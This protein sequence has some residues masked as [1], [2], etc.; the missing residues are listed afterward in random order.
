MEQWSDTPDHWQKGSPVTRTITIAAQG[1][2]A[3]QIPDLNIAKMPGVNIYTD[4]AKRRNIKKD[5][6]VT[7]MLEQK[8]TYIPTTADFIIIPELKLN[9]WDLKT[10]TNALATLNTLAVQIKTG[11][12]NTADSST[13]TLANKALKANISSIPTASKNQVAPFYL[14]IWFWLAAL[15]FVMWVIT[16]SLFR[17]KRTNDGSIINHKPIESNMDVEL[18]TTDIDFKL[19]CVQGN[20]FQAQ[21]YILGWAKQKWP[22]MPINLAKLRGLVDDSNF[23]SASVALEIAVYSK[24]DSSWKGD[25][26]LRAF[27]LVEKKFKGKSGKI[28]K[29]KSRQMETDSPLPP[30]NP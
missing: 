14:S 21:E 3:D 30:L 28:V 1:L 7:G 19:A 27:K 12:N 5:N 18:K 10:N 16:L 20:P 17:A 24:N 4:A 26:L 29:G 2:R 23:N 11:V 22:D 8:F 9:W 15:L 13:A 25:D 6:T